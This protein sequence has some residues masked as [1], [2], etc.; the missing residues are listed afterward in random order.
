MTENII[1]IVINYILKPNKGSM[2]RSFCQQ[3]IYFE[4]IF[5][6]REN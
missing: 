5:I 6:R 4:I 1:K 2:D 3:D